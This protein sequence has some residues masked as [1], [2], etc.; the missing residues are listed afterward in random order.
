MLSWKNLNKNAG[1]QT[2]TAYGDDTV[3]GRRT[4]GSL[5]QGA[6][7][8]MEKRRIQEAEKKKQKAIQ[9][10]IDYQTKM[11]EPP[12]ERSGSL[13][14]KFENTLEG[15][16]EF[17][18]LVNNAPVQVPGETK[19]NF[20]NRLKEY[21]A[22]LKDASDKMQGW[23]GLRAVNYKDVTESIPI[24][25]GVVKEIRKLADA[26]E[27]GDVIAQQTLS[28]VNSN[29]LWNATKEVT[30]AVAKDVV[31][32]PARIAL[33]VYGIAGARPVSV[34]IPGLGEVNN[35]YFDTA[36][37]IANGE[38]PWVVAIEES[39]YAIL[40]ILFFGSIASKLFVPRAVVVS[41]K[42]KYSTKGLDIAGGKGP[43]GI[44]ISKAKSGRLYT[45]KTVSQRIPQ[46]FVD[47]A[48]QEGYTFNNKFDPTAPTFFKVASEADGTITGRVVQLRPPLISFG[49]KPVTPKE[50]PNIK[51]KTNVKDEE[52]EPKPGE[53]VLWEKS[54]DP[55]HIQKVVPNVVQKTA[56]VLQP[57]K[58]PVVA[59]L[60]KPVPP[61]IEE[62]KDVL[63]SKMI[64]PEEGLQASPADMEERWATATQDYQDNVVAPIEQKID[65]IY[66]RLDILKGTRDAAEKNEVSTLNDRVKQL[67]TLKEKGLQV[68]EAEF[69]DF[70]QQVAEKAVER[71]QSAG[72]DLSGNRL[73]EFQN[74]V[75]EQ[76]EGPGYREANFDNSIE[77]IVDAVLQR[78][79]KTAPKKIK[80]EKPVVKDKI[81]LD[82]ESEMQAR[83]LQELDM[84]EP[85][86]RINVKDDEGYVLETLGKKS[87][88]PDWI[89]DYLRR[90]KI[91][92]PVYEHILND[93]LPKKADEVRLYN[94]IAERMAAKDIAEENPGIDFEGLFKEETADEKK[95]LE[96]FNNLSKSNEK[97]SKVSGQKKGENEVSPQRGKEGGT[98]KGEK[99]KRK[100]DFEI[101]KKMEGRSDKEI[102]DEYHKDLNGYRD[103]GI[104]FEGDRQPL[105]ANLL[106]V[107]E[108]VDLPVVQKHVKEQLDKAIKDGEVTKNEDDTIT[109]FRAG[110]IPKD[111]RLTSVTY[112]YEYAQE[113]ASGK[114]LPI[115]EF[116]IKEDNVKSFIG[117]MEKELLV[118]SD[119]LVSMPEQEPA[120]SGYA[121]AYYKDADTPE[122]PIKMGT[123]DNIRPLE[124]PEIVRLAKE[125]LDGGPLAVVKSMGMAAG[126][127]SPTGKGRI[128]ILRELFKKGNEKELSKVLAHE[129]GH[130]ID[131]LPTKTMARGNL[132]GR[133]N[134][135]R[136][137]LKGTFG[138]YEI[139]NKTVR[140][141]LLKVTQELHPYDPNTVPASYLKYRESAVE[142]Y[143]EAI[144]MLLNSPG[145]L[146]EV[147]PNFYKGFFNGLDKKP[148]VRD[149]YFGIQELLRQG[150]EKITE[151]RRG[152]V[153]ESFMRSDYKAVELERIREAQEKAERKSF[154]LRFK[155]GSLSNTSPFQEKLKESKK[156]GVV[157]N[158]NDNP[159]YYM[160]EGRYVE[161][162]IKGM[163]EDKFSPIIDELREAGMSEIDLGEMLFYE[164]ILKGDRGEVA[165]PQGLQPD[166]VEEIFGES[167]K[168]E[169]KIV[170]ENSNSLK[171][172]LGEEKFAILKDLAQRYRNGLK[173]V[174]KQGYDEGLYT[175]E[176]LKM[177]EENKFYVPFKTQKYMG[178]KT[179]FTVRAKRGTLSDIENP[180][181]TTIEKAV[182]IV[183]AIERNKT[184]RVS[185]TFLRDN[186]PADIEASKKRYV[187]RGHEI[188]ETRDPKKG[189][190][191]YMEKGKPVG[192]D[193]DKYIA[194]SIKNSSI[195][196]VHAIVETLNLSNSKWFRPVFTTFSV[197]FQ[198]GFNP[199]RDFKRYWRNMP[200]MSFPRAVHNYYKAFP[201]AFRK[202][203]EIRDETVDEMYRQ[204]VLSV[205][206]NDVIK[207]ATEE[208]TQLELILERL[209]IFE[210]DGRMKGGVVKRGILR[211]GA[212]IER[213]GNVMEALPKIAGYMEFK[214]KGGGAPLSMSD[215]DFIRRYV[216]SPDFLEK[217][218]WTKNT[219][220]IFLFSN[221]I[222]QGISS[223]LELA[224]GASTRSGFWWKTAKWSILPKIL[225]FAA[226]AGAFGEYVKEIM[227][228]AT[229][230]DK[231][232]YTIIPIGVDQNGKAVYFR[233]P[234]DETGRFIS[235]IF[236]KM[237]NVRE[238]GQTATQDV[239]DIISLFGGQLPTV[240][241][242]I[243]IPY[244]IFKFATGQNVYDSFTQRNILSDDQMAAGWEYK[245]GPVLQYLFNQAGGN[246][247]VKLY[248][249]DKAL[250]QSGLESVIRIPFLSNLLARFIRVTDYGTQEKLDR[251][252]MPLERE[253]AETRIE[254]KKILNQYIGK[255]RGLEGDD[256]KALEDELV[257]KTLG[258]E[259]DGGRHG[260]EKSKETNLR[261]RFEV[262]RIAG[263]V[264]NEVDALIYAQSNDEKLA[265][266]QSYKQSMSTE[267]FDTLMA[268]VEENK[269][270]SEN[271][272]DSFNQ[273]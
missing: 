74:Q 257:E 102:I 37:R 198:L 249:T 109:V 103:T 193:V 155:H 164:R 239:E 213:M 147:A 92:K 128:R 273:Q 81:E 222:I 89:P 85:G 247:F 144:S 118:S 78:F 263:T 241:P 137:Y 238:N 27:K 24:I 53:I 149:S 160:R 205:S 217:G 203:F 116:K 165:N 117:G 125:L 157:T 112:S 113:F 234:D 57:D 3:G 91:V 227:D 129:I 235:A 175:D 43:G 267:D 190:V 266:L 44:E 36:Q 34:N 184:S 120:P 52:T 254:N 194:D 18:N 225:M 40:D 169:E 2:Q 216:G 77:N 59:P 154:W 264:S 167:V 16:S 122:I 69:L 140:E 84:A 45:T 258:P 64:T 26:A 170:A 22:R 23:G 221:A 237:M 50:T 107:S 83:I 183:R 97:V 230:Y 72:A 46:Y 188:V 242:A 108:F 12:K 244:D 47:R 66:K 31:A 131:Y 19:Q 104:G 132:I 96:D 186:F 121:M 150:P 245:A 134:T 197:G 185:L 35:A 41:P 141:E 248:N 236:W 4:W 15:P 180:V 178:E 70:K 32:T 139:K 201:K 272:V 159:L 148:E 105:N 261:K 146:Q 209:N 80:R 260:T 181:N 49:K 111:G 130:L 218:T 63:T 176:L 153:R 142:L 86:E 240:T 224:T 99:R 20:L 8:Y 10:Q 90:S 212:T 195:Q 199:I 123:L 156:L 161:G 61:R 196:E 214:R 223:D 127:F 25:G 75:V 173:E 38:N 138:D 56:D 65:E 166:Y 172:E 211:V 67:F 55:E 259:P 269:I 136:K 119:D 115:S 82:A 202:G 208:D 135:L 30:A 94:L 88:F 252:L 62:P 114:N 268:F 33:N 87:S 28:G 232:N 126:K 219:N 171:S 179:R 226:G 133:L 168:P 187:Y 110:K 246:V 39:S 73:K 200:G 262:G 265:L 1:G 100:V 251:E 270:I 215:K 177:A 207:G 182:A 271:V 243:S 253:A 14:K 256:L 231:T 124:F 42:M 151:A 174:F 233:L 58:P 76:I 152:G 6:S 106:R 68:I 48:V 95:S 5:N 250:P 71:A 191:I 60:S 210:K 51:Q 98:E 11:L 54:V 228:K 13:W 162:K 192:Y 204:G 145:H 17:D 255:S 29:D 143:A 158:P 189:T 7:I 93:T 101:A 163:V 229:E 9:D 79:N 220:S 21:E 206:F